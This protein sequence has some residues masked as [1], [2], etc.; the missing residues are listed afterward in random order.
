MK[1]GAFSPQCS[2]VEQNRICTLV[3]PSFTGVHIPLAHSDRGCGVSA[4]TM[5]GDWTSAD[6][7]NKRP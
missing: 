3:D 5:D 1:H 6:S 2:R 7:E 4:C